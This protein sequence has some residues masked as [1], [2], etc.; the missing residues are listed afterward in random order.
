MVVDCAATSWKLTASKIKLR[1]FT[2]DSK[3]SL[4]GRSVLDAEAAEAAEEHA[5]VRWT[6]TMLGLFWGV[7]I[8]NKSGAS[9]E[10]AADKDNSI[11]KMQTLQAMK[12]P[13]SSVSFALQRALHYNVEEVRVEGRSM[14][15][16]T[17]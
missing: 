8:W 12:A 10:V 17:M 11:F 3:R 2:W 16:E 1:T 5:V 9:V 13:S 15:L 14:A 4:F 6:R 7:A